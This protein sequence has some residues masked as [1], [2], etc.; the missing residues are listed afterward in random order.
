MRCVRRL[1][2]LATFLMLALATHVLAARAR[3]ET[4]KN[5]P[6]L[7]VWRITNDPSVRDH[8]NYHNT[9]CWSPDGRY[10]CYTHWG[11]RDDKYGTKSGA[12]VHVFDL[13]K[14][15]D[16]RVDQGINPRWAKRHNWLFYARFNPDAGPLPETGT[17][18]MRLDADRG[19]LS[20]LVYGVEV[21]GG[22][23]ADDRWLYG[24]QRFR[25]QTPPRKVVRIRTSAPDQVEYL[26]EVTGGQLL[27][28]PRHP[29]F[30]TRHDHRDQPFGATRYWFD[31]EGR[32]RRIFSPTVQQCHMGWLGN[33]D[34]LLHGNGLIRG[35]RWDEP[36]PS[37]MHFLSRMSLGD[38]SPCGRSGRYVCGDSVVADLRSGDGWRFIHPL[39]IICYPATIKDNSG[40]YDADPKG[41][42]DGTKICFVS[43][44]D[45][46]D[47]PLT[48]IT[49]PFSPK[50]NVLHVE[51]TEDFPEAGSLVVSREVIGY[52]R[53]TPTT[54]ERITR[55]RYD[56]T[57][58][59]LRPGRIVTSFEARCLADEQ[60]QRLPRPSPAMRQSIDDP[61]SPLLRQRQTD[62]YV[63]IVRRPDRPHLRL[64][65]DRAQIIPGQEHYETCGYYVLRNGAKISEDPVRPGASVSLTEPGEYTAVAVEWSGLESE[66]GP[67][68]RIKQPVRLYALADPPKD[69]S[70]TSD[71]WLVASK[72]VSKAE[73]DQAEEAVREIVHLH[74]GV[75]HREWHR[76]GVITRRH[77][78]NREG[79]AI[80]RL[81]YK[82]GRLGL[83]EYYRDPDHRVSKEVFAPDG[84]ITESVRYRYQG[85][86][87]L[88]YDHW[89]YDRGMPI[90]RI[91]RERD[92][93]VKRGEDWAKMERKK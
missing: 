45:L 30:F 89:W 81:A 43:N 37:N 8:A 42:P 31:L 54:F 83:R 84:Y 78:L 39:S 32:G 15:E 64:K 34:Y 21:L 33:G 19:K 50:E 66:P 23:N 75:I 52:Q 71:R 36:F 28:N 92:E 14:D 41:S 18:V 47:G 6:N 40:I 46:K 48:T 26:P 35:R 53:K 24:A 7:G 55:Q 57:R 9:Q 65:E 12:H 91:L 2:I 3:F 25:G 11:M 62:I 70:W 29:V 20:H 67:P 49:K 90:R 79:T 58:R 87:A 16:K 1:R 63:A 13:H 86:R 27:P 61:A 74:D 85:E 5:G 69:F 17:E 51:S 60:W 73:A 4:P 77:D 44:Y 76:R 68:L 93:Y 88:E 72:E 80:R 59:P 22:T 56:T 38:V 10:L 82:D